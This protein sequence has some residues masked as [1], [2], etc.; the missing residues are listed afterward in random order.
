MRKLLLSLPVVLLLTGCGG[1]YKGDPQWDP[2]VISK[3]GCPNL[4]GKYKNLGVADTVPR[5]REKIELF[6]HFLPNIPV[7]DETTPLTLTKLI[8]VD[9]KQ[10]SLKE[11]E[12]GNL[13]F[14]QR[15]RLLEVIFLEDKTGT[16]RVKYTLDMN[17]P[18]VG[19]HDGALIFR[20]LQ[21]H[22]GGPW[23]ACGIAWAKDRA[24]RKLA[25][26]SLEVRFHSREWRCSMRGE[27][28]QREKGV[29][30]FPPASKS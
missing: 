3:E 29:E 27:P 25:D 24:F 26:G 5:S 30:I 20:R 7:Y 2:P 6:R 23:G 9:A 14:Q 28:K 22:H 19:C 17:H 21:M 8:A 16:P 15:G 18:R 10:L 4:D 1:I 12:Q 13:V 11:I